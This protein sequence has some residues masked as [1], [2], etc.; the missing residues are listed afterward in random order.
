MPV[1]TIWTV[2]H[3]TRSLAELVEL[4]KQNRIGLLV[5]VRTAPGSRRL[6]HFS[7]AALAAGLPP[8]G[9]AYEHL[10]ALGGL[11]RP[12]GSDEN[13]GWRNASFRAYADHMQTP[14]FEAGLAALLERA[15]SRRTAIMCAEAVP[16]RC[17]R[18]LI[19]DA[20]VARGH[21]VCHITGRGEPRE[22]ELTSFARVEGSRVTYPP[23]DTLPL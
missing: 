19:S 3:S 20:L 1:S 14:E 17:H 8:L 18:S 23:A 10:P 2:G 4:L 11:R 13:A 15:A 22:H 12:T 16:W 5:D 7:R 9:V 6:P 21:H